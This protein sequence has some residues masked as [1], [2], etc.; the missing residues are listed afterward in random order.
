MVAEFKNGCLYAEG[1]ASNSEVFS[2][3]GWH[4]EVAARPPW[5]YLCHG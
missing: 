1:N 4:P 3:E 5:L 2:Q